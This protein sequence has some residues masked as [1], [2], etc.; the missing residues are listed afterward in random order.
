MIGDTIRWISRRDLNETKFQRCLIESNASI[1]AQPWYLDAAAGG[2]WGSLVHEDYLSV[3]PIT[4]REFLGFRIL[5]RPVLVQSLG[6]YPIDNPILEKAFLNKINEAIIS[7]FNLEDKYEFVGRKIFYEQRVNYVLPLSDVYPTILD[8]FRK[9]RRRAL[10]KAQKNDLRYQDRTDFNALFE[11]YK[12]TFGPSKLYTRIL[13]I[14][15]AL[16]MQNAGFQRNVYHGNQIVSR[17]Y[18]ALWNHRIY[19]LFGAT[20]PTGKRLGAP[21]FLINTVLEQYAHSNYIFD[22]E[23][24]MIPSVAKFYQSFGAEE[25]YYYALKPNSMIT[26]IRKIKNIILNLKTGNF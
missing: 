10:R 7:D 15:Q 23:G 16:D 18:F 14:L 5:I 17:A 26:S 6:I 22:F 19:Y 12:G 21:T 8:G 3:L 20:N 25:E 13:Q 24:S 9:D 4:Y 1:Y 11:L 2:K